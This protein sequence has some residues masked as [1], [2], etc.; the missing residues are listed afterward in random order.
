MIQTDIIPKI[1]QFCRTHNETL[2]KKDKDF[3]TIYIPKT[4]NLYRLPKIHKFEE[5]KIAL[6]NQ[7][8]EYIEIQTPVTANSD[9]QSN[10]APPMD[11]TNCGLKSNG[12]DYSHHVCV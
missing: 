10:H 9:L 7:K 5:I 8:P 1:T 2:T 4:S 6:E 12:I 11:L 3:L